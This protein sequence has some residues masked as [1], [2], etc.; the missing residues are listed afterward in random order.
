MRRTASS[1]PRSSWNVIGGSGR[2]TLW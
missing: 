1:P 2:A